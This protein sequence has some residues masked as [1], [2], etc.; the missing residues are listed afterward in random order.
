MKIAISG[1]HSVGKSTFVQDFHAQYP[2]YIYEQEP[3]RA[4]R[5]KHDI[6]FAETGTR[7]HYDLQFYHSLFNLDKH[8]S[9]ENVIFDRLSCR[10]D[11]ILSLYG[12]IWP[13]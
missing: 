3:F 10:H 2:D 4:P 1:T 7:H 8:I 5:D 12:Q 6:E 13:Y 9:S 11:S